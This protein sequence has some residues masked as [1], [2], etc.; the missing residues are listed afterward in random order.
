MHA[1]VRLFA[2]GLALVIVTS[3]TRAD[4][5]AKSAK[6]R[7][8]TF[9][10]TYSATVTDLA[11]G[12]TARIWLPV[13]PSNAEQDVKIES[14]ELPA[15]GKIGRESVYGNQILY[16]EAA[17]G[18]DGTIPL[19]VAYKV[20]RRE[21]GAM[22]QNPSDDEM[23]MALYVQPNALVPITGKP[24]DLIK[25]KKVPTDQL[26]AAR[27]FYDVV[28]GHM[29][30]SKEGEGW[31]RGDSNWACDSGYGNCTD[32]HSLF[33][34]LARSRK[35]PAKFEI[36]LPLPADKTSGEIPGYHCW[37]LFYLE[38]TGWVPVDAS[39]AWKNPARREYYFGAF[40]PDRVLFAQGRDI[41]LSPPQA[42]DPLN[43][44]VHPYA[45]LDGRPFELGH[46]FSFHDR[47]SQ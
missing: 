21:A 40:D 7:S 14:K 32:F 8:R 23:E 22:S 38:G 31:G 25:D 17:A 29:R 16:L 24:L 12:T 47:P 41:R 1:T 18:K 36:G 27:V 9:L 11:P 19:K 37:A 42:G 28:N 13:P 6:P 5:P 34:S 46:K 2:A 4:E 10:F 26:A 45:E 39:E 43:Y 44:F 20:T 30:Y 3:G 15:E 35:I 33:I